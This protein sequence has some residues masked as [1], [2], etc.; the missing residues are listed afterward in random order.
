MFL[1][2]GDPPSLHI[3]INNITHSTAVVA[4]TPF[5]KNESGVIKVSGY[6]VS[7]KSQ[8]D[9]NQV[10]QV[11]ES[12]SSLL[13]EDLKTFTKYC[14]NV[15]PL[16]ALAGAGKG[17]CHHFITGE[18]GKPSA[19]VAYY[20]CA[21]QNTAVVTSYRPGVV[22]SPVPYFCDHPPLLTVVIS[23]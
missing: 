11:D 12:T 14:V 5:L 21:C 6:K 10:K 16:T 20:A 22:C 3:E 9:K 13:F 7:V 2:L 17:D 1:I 18:N 8:Y 19:E 4:W 23:F 15:E